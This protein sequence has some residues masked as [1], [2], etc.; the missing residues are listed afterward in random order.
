MNTPRN[1]YKVGFRCLSRRN[2]EL[3]RFTPATT[4]A[5]FAVD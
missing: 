5:T 1:N 4:S 3:D 2:K